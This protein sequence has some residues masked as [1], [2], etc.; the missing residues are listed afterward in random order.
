MSK[1]CDAGVHDGRRRWPT[2]DVRIRFLLSQTERV[3]CGDCFE[4]M[5][6]A[7]AHLPPGIVEVTEL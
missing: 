7:F 6:P 2:A 4:E 1:Q 3:Y 5:E